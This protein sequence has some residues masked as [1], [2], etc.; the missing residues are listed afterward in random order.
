MNYQ[1]VNT[2]VPGF[3][4]DLLKPFQNTEDTI[5][6]QLTDSMDIVAFFLPSDHSFPIRCKDFYFVFDIIEYIYIAANLINLD[7]TRLAKL[8]VSHEINDSI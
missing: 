1:L 6:F 5:D 7:I 4:L 8:S 2:P 3:S